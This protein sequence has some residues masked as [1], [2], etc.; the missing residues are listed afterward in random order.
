M[1]PTLYIHVTLIQPYGTLKNDAP[2]RLYGIQAVEITDPG[3][4]LDPVIAMKEELEPE[5]DFTVT[6]K[7]SQGKGMTY[8]LAIVDEG[9]LDLTG[10]KTP[11]PHAHFLLGSLGSEDLRSFRQGGG[12]L[13]SSSGEGFCGRGDEELKVT[14]H[15]QANRF[16]PVVLLPV[17]SLSR[18]ERPNHISSGCPIM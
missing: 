11:D 15:R 7:E 5:K 6:V 16:Q 10:F 18:K 3:T 12:G 2:I 9:L 4:L 17:P 8:T 13:W 1:A 14:G